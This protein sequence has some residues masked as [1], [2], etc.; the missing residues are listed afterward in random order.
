MT[1]AIESTS[2][3]PEEVQATVEE[4]LKERDQAVPETTSTDE[5]P[6]PDTVSTQSQDEPSSA[7][8]ASERATADDE[9]TPDQDETVEPP[10]GSVQKR[11]N[12]ALKAK[13][14][15]L[16]E[17]NDAL[18]RAKAL[19][20][21]LEAV[22][23]KTH[24]PEP[25]DAP[26]DEPPEPNTPPVAVT[27]AKPDLK[28]FDSYEDWV[29]AVSEWK[30]DQ[31]EA[32]LRAEIQAE[33]DAKLKAEHEASASTEAQKQVSAV[34][35]TYNDRLDAARGRIP[36]FDKVLDDAGEV[37]LNDAMKEA[38][39]LRESGPDVLYYLATHLDVAEE[40]QAMNPAQTYMEL[41]RIEAQLASTEPAADPDKLNPETT[42]AVTP[43]TATTPAISKAPTPLKTVETAVTVSEMADDDPNLPYAEYKRRREEHET[44]VGRR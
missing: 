17:K 27:K 21:E 14:E 4:A 12:R 13:H 3:T 1:I 22:K 31:K 37:A 5:T 44:R 38:I 10:S 15:A 7:D 33:M 34:L 19:E 30:W 35:D 36:D 8:A 24:T 20:A 26:V 32:K 18:A 39:I 28:D 29:E 9:A 23:A 16:A 43:K 41:G 42:E 2:D 11:I 6:T 40:I 25:D